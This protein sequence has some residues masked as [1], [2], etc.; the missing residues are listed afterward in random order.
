MI[1]LNLFHIDKLNYCKCVMFKV[2]DLQNFIALS[3]GAC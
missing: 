3:I 2:D 1:L